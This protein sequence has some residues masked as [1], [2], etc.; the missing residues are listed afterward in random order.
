MSQ[1]EKD[2]HD[3]LKVSPK[4]LSSKYF[5]DEKG[6]N[7][8]VKIMGMPE[9]YLTNC[10][11]EIFSRQTEELI[12]SF[13]VN[14][15]EFEL[16]ELGAGDGT[17][18]IELL[19]GL[20]G[21][22]SY[23]YKPIDISQHALDGLKYKLAKVLPDLNVETLQG[24]YF[25]VLSGLKNGKPKVVLFLGSNIGNMRDEAA[26]TF[27]TQL[28]SQLVKG[29]KLLLGVDLIKE[30]SIVL[31]AYNDA[32]GFT[33]EFNL[34]LLHRINRELNGNIDVSQ[35]KHAPRYSEETGIAES[36]LE[37]TCD[38]SIKIGDQEYHFKEGEKIHMEI[39]RK[40]NDEILNKILKDT[41]FRVLRKFTDSR[42]YFADYLLER[43]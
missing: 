21:K 32:Q 6:D 37:S 33:R 41:G 20:S 10:E 2:V 7:L 34:N 26:H 9:Y 28:G 14:G 15:E 25:K 42:N 30:T 29:D 27:L 3:G 13:G 38:Q 17:K 4:Q 12:R 1:F 8:F 5:Y 18:T 36:Y 23:T 35:F 43:I 22:H 24:E 40:Y 31:P 19:K 39:S 16:V 11:F